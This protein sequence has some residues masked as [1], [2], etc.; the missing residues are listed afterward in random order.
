MLCNQCNFS[1]DE[2]NNFCPKCGVKINRKPDYQLPLIIKP[3]FLPTVIMLSAAP[4][5]L[6][7]TILCSIFFG[8]IINSAAEELN[9]EIN[10]H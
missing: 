5:H 2:A 8:G 9:I 3:K 1:F 6:F 10:Y 7:L 4:I